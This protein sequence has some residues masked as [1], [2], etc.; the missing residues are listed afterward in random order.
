MILYLCCFNNFE[1]QKFQILK[2]LLSSLKKEVLLHFLQPCHLE[3][4][5]N[6]I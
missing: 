2:K 3:P 1:L 4:I 6:T 5:S